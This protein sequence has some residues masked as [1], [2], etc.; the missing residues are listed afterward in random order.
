M[1]PKAWSP[2][3]W[4]TLRMNENVFIVYGRRPTCDIQNG[5]MRELLDIWALER[6]GFSAPPFS[7]PR[8]LRPD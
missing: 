1:R 5:R 7:A 8:I 3:P 2:S 6:N 4:Y